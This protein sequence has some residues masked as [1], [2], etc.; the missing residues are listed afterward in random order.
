MRTWRVLG[1]LVIGMIV[2]LPVAGYAQASAA[3]S[4]PLLMRLR[5]DAAGST[6]S[7]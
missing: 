7:M 5:R 4:L 1:S 6:M 3:P 2:A